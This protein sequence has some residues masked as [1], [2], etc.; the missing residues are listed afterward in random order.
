MHLSK[1]RAQMLYKTAPESTL[2]LTNVEEATSGAADTVDQ[3]GRCTGLKQT[4]HIRLGFTC[5]SANLVYYI[6]C[7]RCGLLYIGESKCRLSGSFVEHLRSVDSFVHVWTK[8]DKVSNSVPL[9]EPKL[10]LNEQLLA[11]QELLDSI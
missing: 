9:A 5:I 6:R 4:F 1:Y 8:T 2:G 7:S 3:V 11:E 10:S